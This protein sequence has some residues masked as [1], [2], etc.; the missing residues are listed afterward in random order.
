MDNQNVSARGTEAAPRAAVS[1]PSP[2]AA[3]ASESEA[4]PSAVES[5]SKVGS[6]GREEENDHSSDRKASALNQSSE[7][8]V[9]MHSAKRTGS[10]TSNYDI[11]GQQVRNNNS[12]MCLQPAAQ[13]PGVDQRELAPHA[14]SYSTDERLKQERLKLLE[15]RSIEL[16]RQII[17]QSRRL[18]MQRQEHAYNAC[19]WDNAAPA[20]ASTAQNSNLVQAAEQSREISVSNERKRS[21]SDLYVSPRHSVSKQSTRQSEDFNESGSSESSISSLSCSSKDAPSSPSTES[22]NESTHTCKPDG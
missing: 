19:N 8:V 10:G 13:A 1:D 21:L 9:A 12:G 2:P 14:V 15:I 17:E 22:K 18:A 11:Y 6:M 4:A 3:R 7:D 20:S 16:G 5:S